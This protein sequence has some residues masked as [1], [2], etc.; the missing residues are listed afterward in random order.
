MYQVFT[1]Y[2]HFQRGLLNSIEVEVGYLMKKPLA[3]NLAL[4]L[5]IVP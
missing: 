4:Y 2:V 3:I 1:L 5:L